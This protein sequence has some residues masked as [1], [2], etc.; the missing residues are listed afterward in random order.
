MSTFF[1]DRF[2]IDPALLEK[3]GAFN[4]SIIT[5][6]PLFI[7]P[8]LLFNS[9]KPKYKELHNSIVQYLIFLKE[10]AQ[11]GSVTEGLLRSWYCF[12]EVKQNWLGFS[13][14]G[15]AGSG[16]GIDFGRAL[17]TNL[18]ALFPDLGLEQITKGTHLEK[19]CLIREGVG[20]DNISDFVTN[21]IKGY[22]CQYTEDFALANIDINSHK[23]ISISNVEFNYETETWEPRTYV[24]PWSDGDFILLTP[25]DLLTRDENWINRHDMIRDFEKIPTAIRDGQLRA[26]VTNYF[27]KLLHRQ[28]RRGPTQ[29]ERDHAAAQTIAAFPKLIDYFI[30]YKEINGKKAEDISSKKV[31]DTH[32]LFVAQLKQLQQHLSTDTPFYSSD[33]GTYEEAHHRI[34][35]LKDAIENKGCHRLFYVGGQPIKREAD[36]QIMYR[37]VW[38]GT[39]SDV[40]TE[41]NDGRGPADF[42]ISRGARDKTI[43]ELKLAS[44]SHL[45][46]NLQ[47]QAEIYMKASDA[48]AAIKGILFFTRQEQIKVGKLLKELKLE[49]NKD[50][51]LIDARNDNK[52]SGSKARA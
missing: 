13:K 37:L 12:P 9:K 1:S 24:L 35:Y 49:N 33:G 5:D 43:V 18:N 10:K 39:T 41:A 32:V 45:R 30:R 34:A 40:T 6:L 14:T 19:V 51:V 44:N 23:E 28:K 4:I 47:K 31:F 46:N 20:R 52:P 38:I 36:L 48:K 21:L 42:K 17:H 26:Q 15:N 25:K 8:F 11:D 7:D 16:L 27:E 22:L 2:A 3:Y 29:K 50:V